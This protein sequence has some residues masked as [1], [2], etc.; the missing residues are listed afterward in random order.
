[1]KVSQLG[2]LHIYLLLYN[3]YSVVSTHRADAVKPRLV[4]H[5]DRHMLQQCFSLYSFMCSDMWNSELKR[6]KKK[7]SQNWVTKSTA[8][9]V[10]QEVQVSNPDGK[11]EGVLQV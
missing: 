5:N 6:K 7:L 8:S 4:F 10:T 1:M 9:E 3:F 2:V 11:G